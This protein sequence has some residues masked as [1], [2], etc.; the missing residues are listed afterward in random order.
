MA[1]QITGASIVC[2]TVCSGTDQRKYQSIASLA[3]VREIHLWPVNSPHKGSV[4]R[5][6]LP[7]D[8]VTMACNAMLPTNVKSKK[9]F[10]WLITFY[11]YPLRNYDYWCLLHLG[12][13]FINFKLSPDG[14]LLHVCMKSHLVCLI[15]CDRFSVTRKM[16]P[17]D[18]VI[19]GFQ[20]NYYLWH[21]IT[22][23][24]Y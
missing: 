6:I 18:D 15:K 3:F 20:H 13:I 16:F 23:V 4:T 19:M 24:V 5:K 8:D 12:C 11:S 14:N 9:Y 10:L 1:S 7:F 2:S 21:K 17:F 22:L